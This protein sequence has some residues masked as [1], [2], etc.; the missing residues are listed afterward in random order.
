M[1]IR[2]S[3]TTQI[4]VHQQVVFFFCVYQTYMR[5]VAKTRTNLH[6]KRILTVSLQIILHHA[7]T[8]KDLSMSADDECLEMR[9]NKLTGGLTRS[10]TMLLSTQQ[11]S[12]YKTTYISC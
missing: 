5:I 12:L 10:A 4:N 9:D 6:T 3:L 1:I 8:P 11:H 2:A 7:S